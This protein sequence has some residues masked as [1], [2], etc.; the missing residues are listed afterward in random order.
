M[1][2]SYVPWRQGVKS[3]F[4]AALDKK[5]FDKLEKWVNYGLNEQE[6][7]VRIY[8]MCATWE[9]G[10]MIFGKGHVSEDKDVYVL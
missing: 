10:I 8:P 5:L 4:E 3:V 6:D 1:K 7:S 9:T 2:G